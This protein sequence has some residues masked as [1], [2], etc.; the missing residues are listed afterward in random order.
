[1]V[2]SPA[3]ALPRHQPVRSRATSTLDALL[4]SAA[5]IVHSV[6]AE[7]LTSE[8]V[9]IGSGYSIGTVYRYFLNRLHILDALSQQNMDRFVKDCLP[10]ITPRRHS[11]WLDA[12][13]SVLDYFEL[14]FATRP[15]FRSIRFGDHLDSR[16]GARNQTN[17]ARAASI[18]AS[19][20]GD[21]YPAIVG[22]AVLE[23][24]EVA[25]LIHDSLL[26]RAFAHSDLG[27]TRLI[28]DSR[29]VAISYLTALDPTWL[30]PGSTA[31]KEPLASS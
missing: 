12:F 25:L 27:D 29:Q 2:D 9:G 14:E 31:P 19:T 8:L 1:M 13:T 3:P 17:I 16:I 22:T 6:G 30:A 23:R 18:F 5:L 26:A 15:G 11:T 7:R 10:S 4:K 24:I 28:A 20:L 21:N